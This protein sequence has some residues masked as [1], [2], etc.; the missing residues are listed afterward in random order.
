[1]SAAGVNSKCTTCGHVYTTIGEAVVCCTFVPS[2]PR[3]WCLYC[4]DDMSEK[5]TLAF[6]SQRCARFFRFDVF[7]EM[8]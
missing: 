3:G 2:H 1:M 7:E 5:T 6:C 4:G 8:T